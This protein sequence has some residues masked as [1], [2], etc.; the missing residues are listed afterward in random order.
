MLKNSLLCYIAVASSLPIVTVAIS[1]LYSKVKELL[2]SKEKKRI[3][4][5]QL[6]FCY[7]IRELKLVNS[8]GEYP[9]DL[10]IKFIDHGFELQF[11]IAGICSYKVIESN[12]DFIANTFGAVQIITENSKGIVKLVIFME[13]LEQ[14]DYKKYILSPTTL[15]C[16]Y[17]YNG[18]ITVDMLKVPHMLIAGLSGQG[19]SRMVNYMLNNLIDSDIVVLNGFEE[20]Y[21][22]FNLIHGTKEIEEYLKQLLEDKS[23]RDKPLYIVL[24]EMQGLSSNS[25]IAKLCKELLSYGRHYNIYCIGIIQI[26]TKENCKF[27]DLFNCR[28]TYKQCDSSAYSVCLGVSVDK[29]LKQREFYLY[30]ANGVD[31]QFIRI[32]FLL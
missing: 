16:G 15:L 31:R 29:D 30:G 21:K 25:S 9:K 22:G 17:N 13:E 11:N 8:I 20:D 24:E 2:K 28:L 27:K 6:N 5:I 18:F 26:A 12:V 1:P 10:T 23:K 7:V 19:K 3:E 4:Q 14:L 32:K